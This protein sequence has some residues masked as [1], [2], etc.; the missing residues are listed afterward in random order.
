MNPRPHNGK[1]RQ[2]YALRVVMAICLMP[3]PLG[4]AD[5]PPAELERLFYTPAQRAQLQAD[6]PRPSTDHTQA[7]L[8][9]SPDA[10]PAPVQFDGV[11]I[12]SDGKTTRWVDGKAQVGATGISNMKPGQIRANGKVY[13]PY[14]LLRPE[15][16]A[17]SEKE[18][19]P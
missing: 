1:S 6:R 5:A 8:P 14:Q 9:D 13:E 11:L 17:S 10:A 3:L 12:R 19:T 16:A 2:R 4:A 7:N 15:P 18:A